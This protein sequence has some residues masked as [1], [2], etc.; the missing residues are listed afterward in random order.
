[1]NLVT[2]PYRY[3]FIPFSNPRYLAISYFPHLLHHMFFT[4]HLTI[5]SRVMES[6]KYVMNLSRF[7]LPRDFLTDLFP[8]N[9]DFFPT[10]SSVFR[11]AFLHESRDALRKFLMNH[12]SLHITL[13]LSCRRNSS[14][15]S[16]ITSSSSLRRLSCKLDS[17]KPREALK[18]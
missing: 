2:S 3:D 14:L 5:G 12:V 13:G 15:C 16:S 6:M 17:M 9:S 4:L 11:P 10:T 8:F 7:I 1:M 18:K